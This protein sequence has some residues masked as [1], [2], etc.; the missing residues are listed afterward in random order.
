MGVVDDGR[1][2]SA[3]EK[4]IIAAEL[5]SY[6]LKTCLISKRPL[7]SGD[8]P[9]DLV[10]NDHLFRVCCL[11]CVDTARAK[12]TELRKVIERAVISAER[13]HWPF[14][15]CPVSGER[16]EES[17][18]DPVELVLDGTG[19]FGSLLD[20]TTKWPFIWSASCH[21]LVFTAEHFLKI[22]FEV[23]VLYSLHNVHFYYLL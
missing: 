8:G 9:F 12:S 22:S 14:K 10:V 2:H 13:A 7:D 1:E 6:P 21:H 15:K 18:S 20:G 5:P 19:P 11:G 17:E 16:Y 3:K 4:A 23:I